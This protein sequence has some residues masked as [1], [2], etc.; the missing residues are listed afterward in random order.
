MVGKN[1]RRSRSSTCHL[2]SIG[3]KVVDDV[4][5]EHL[6]S[7]RYSVGL[8]EGVQGSLSAFK[9]ECGAPESSNV[10]QC[11]RMLATRVQMSC[12]GASLHLD[13]RDEVSLMVTQC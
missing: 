2:K 5:K 11:V 9:A 6:P 7:L 8:R 4:F 10:K 13:V 12:E 1:K 3:V